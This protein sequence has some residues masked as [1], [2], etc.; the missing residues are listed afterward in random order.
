[1][2]ILLAILFTLTFLGFIG[3]G[4]FMFFSKKARTTEDSLF[5][6]L[7]ENSP[8]SHKVYCDAYSIGMFDW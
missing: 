2:S 7:E 1:M 6:N 3:L 5:E 8:D 4:A